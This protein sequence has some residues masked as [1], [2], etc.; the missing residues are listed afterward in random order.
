VAPP[1]LPAPGSGGVG[2][3][4]RS[5]AEQGPKTERAATM[6][7]VALVIAWLAAA[8]FMLIARGD[9]RPRRSIRQK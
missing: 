1:P 4:G 5:S 9:Y 7:S 8:G 3:T 2:A 6:P